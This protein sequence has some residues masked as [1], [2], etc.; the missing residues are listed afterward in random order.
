MNKTL[1]IALLF[2]L[3]AGV[4][5]LALR[6]EFGNSDYGPI[7]ENPPTVALPEQ[8]GGEFDYLKERVDRFLDLNV[9]HF[10]STTAN[11]LLSELQ[12]SKE[13]SVEL[14]RD[15]QKDTSPARQL[16]GLFMELELAGY[17]DALQ[18]H[19]LLQDSIL[20]GAATA[21]WLY[22]HHAF[23]MW[24]SFLQIY[25]ERDVA[26][27]TIQLFTYLENPGGEGNLPAVF[28]VLPV[29]EVGDGFIKEFLRR[30]PEAQRHF[31]NHLIDGEISPSQRNAALV[32][33][34]AISSDHFDEVLN[35]FLA[36]YPEDS[37]S[38]GYLTYLRDQ[39]TEVSLES[40]KPHIDRLGSRSADPFSQLPSV[41]A[42]LE[43]MEVDSD[44]SVERAVL[45]TMESILNGLPV[46]TPVLMKKAADVA[47]AQWRAASP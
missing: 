34:K 22:L 8:Q 3:V 11:D 27:K 2:G 24:S 16:M 18:Q 41:E 40:I 10:S 4:L 36:Q 17:S 39:T 15:L 29:G 47:Y 1:K 30:S 6:N 21:H 43:A 23:D 37:Q 45:E 35:H 44:L 20:F 38:H 13:V 26:E 42:V 31:R 9:G 5:F 19:V 33:L 14:A 28:S 7:A 25:S 46:Q 12:G 32:I